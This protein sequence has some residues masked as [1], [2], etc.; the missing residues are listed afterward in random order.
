MRSANQVITRLLQDP[1]VRKVFG[2]PVDP[3]AL[4]L[5]DY[6]DIIKTPMDLG[7]IQKKLNPHTRHQRRERYS[8]PDCF[9]RDVH[10]TFN[11]AMQYNPPANQ[12]Y[13]L[14]AETFQDFNRIWKRANGG[15]LWS[16]K[17]AQGQNG[18]P[19]KAS[20]G[21]SRSADARSSTRRPKEE[22]DDESDTMRSS[23]KAAPARRSAGG[24]RTRASVGGEGGTTAGGGG[25]A[26]GGEVENSSDEEGRSDSS[27]Y[28][29]PVQRE[30]Q[31]RTRGGRE[32]VRYNAAAPSSS[33]LH[34]RSTG[35]RAPKRSRDY[36]KI[37]GSRIVAE[38][39]VRLRIFE[40]DAS[41]DG[42]NVPKKE[43]DYPEPY[44][45]RPSTVVFEHG[46]RHRVFEY[47]SSDEEKVRNHTLA[48]RGADRDA[49]RAGARPWR[50]RGAGDGSDSGGERGAG[51]SGRRP[52]RR[53]PD[54]DLYAEGGGGSKPEPLNL[55]D[56]DPNV[57]FD[58]I[59]GLDDN[60]R[61][62]KESIFLPLTYPEVFA[63]LGI[64]APKGVLF[65]GPP[66][67]PPP[68]PCSL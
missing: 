36:M 8:G 42:E 34:R 24:R 64:E 66:G 30:Y 43:G 5:D 47:Q 27:G 10:L 46:R 14:A 25:E 2:Q 12:V 48:A 18:S 38:G 9:V 67:L 28:V 65:Y 19:N 31:L 54:L 4:G 44:A 29:R 60:I 51:A 7:T 21:S 37:K 62:L 55:D 22:S 40:T 11:N 52:R 57:S 6:F 45:S 15:Q 17:N 59:G 56:I 32:P 68:A 16:D 13:L 49:G 26:S 61:S 39:G 41:E 1:E 63:K 53:S 33:S 20:G 58:S 23:S 35:A 3:D 50:A